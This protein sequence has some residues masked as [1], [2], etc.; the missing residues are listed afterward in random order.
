[1]VRSSCV[2][3]T[4]NKDLKPLE[5][6]PCEY[7]TDYAR[8]K[9]EPEQS[10]WKVSGMF[11]KQCSWNGACKPEDWKRRGRRCD[12]GGSCGYLKATVLSWAFLWATWGD[13]WDFKQ[14]NETLWPLWLEEATWQAEA[15]TK[16]PV[17]TL[18]RQEMLMAHPRVVRVEEVRVGSIVCF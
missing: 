4:L 1:M 18:L 12:E 13:L 8:S 11:E 10:P 14:R 5:T 9:K 7:L 15:D 3:M 16:L 17:R 2:E 6:Y